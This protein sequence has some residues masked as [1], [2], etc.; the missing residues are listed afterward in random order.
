MTDDLTTRPVVTL[1]RGRSKRAEQGHP[2]IYSNEVALDAAAKALAPGTLVTVAISEGRRLGVATFNPHTLI[3]LRVLDRDPGRRIDAGFFAA[4]LSRALEIRKRLYAEPFY[5]L[6][7]AEADGL[8]GL[9]IDRYGD[10]LVCQ[11]NT[12]GMERLEPMLLEA[13]DRVLSPELV[14][15]RNDGAGRQLEGL[16]AETRTAKG[17]VPERTAVREN[18][19]EF[20]TSLAASQKTG[21][22]YDQ[23]DNRAFVA[24]LAGGARVLDVYSYTGGFGV[25]AAKQGAAEAVLVDRSGGA[26][27]LALEAARANGV[28]DRVQAREGDAFETLTA[29]AEAKERFDVVVLDPPAFVRSK[30]DLGPGSRGYRKLVRLGAAA[31]AKRGILFAASCSHNMPLDAFAEAVRLGLA[32]ADRTG[33]ILRTGFAGP[34]HPVHPALPESAY[35]KAIT[36]AL[37]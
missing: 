8:P 4:R 33:R 22:F 35:L 2:W 5:R 18:G 32:D 9:V 37:D 25:L 27:A 20:V 28:G 21:W 1:A 10:A 13:L 14:V 3:S 12:A 29:L 15:I 26:L 23:R 17:T 16:P 34:D 24:G 7:H 36:L 31:T 11:L 19:A 6:V 30:K